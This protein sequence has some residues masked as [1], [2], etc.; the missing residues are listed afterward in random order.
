MAKSKT[1]SKMSDREIEV[2][3]TTAIEVVETL[4]GHEFEVESDIVTSVKYADG[5]FRKKTLPT[6]LSFF[7]EYA[8]LGARGKTIFGFGPEDSQEYDYAEFSE[9]EV[10]KTFP[11]AGAVLA[12]AHNLETENFGQA[13]A[14]MQTQ[15]AE[16]VESEE[17]EDEEIYKNNPMCG[18]F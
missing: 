18:A 17:I 16:I 12:K 8:Y 1:R 9:D 14:K 10:D 11:L 6:G 13:F 5:S 3:E 15:V 7:L 4:S 2:I